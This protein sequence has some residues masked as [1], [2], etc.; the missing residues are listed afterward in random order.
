VVC[1]LLS[2]F[3]VTAEPMVSLV[4]LLLLIPGCNPSD[5]ALQNNCSLLVK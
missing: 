3:T 2:G 4:L 1:Y 5:E